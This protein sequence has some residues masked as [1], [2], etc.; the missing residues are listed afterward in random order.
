MAMEIELTRPPSTSSNRAERR[1]SVPASATENETP[2]SHAVTVA[3]RWNESKT[4]IWRV[5]A[6]FCGAL[7]M[8]ANDAAYG[9]IIPYVCAAFSTPGD[10]VQC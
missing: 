3:L 9:A 5:L 1:A 8:G 6:T 2:P 4:M 10:H 7:V